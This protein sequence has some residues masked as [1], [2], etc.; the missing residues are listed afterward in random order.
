M[1]MA[2]IWKITRHDAPEHWEDST[3]E[4]SLAEGQVVVLLGKLAASSLA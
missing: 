1:A 2:R 4:D 3:P